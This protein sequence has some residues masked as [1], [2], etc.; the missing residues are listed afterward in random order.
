MTVYIPF[1]HLVEII[2]LDFSPLWL[3]IVLKGNT[4]YLCIKKLIIC[5]GISKHIG[6]FLSPPFIDFDA[7]LSINRDFLSRLCCKLFLLL[8]IPSCLVDKSI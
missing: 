3:I 4:I 7:L 5:Y 8:D 6:F 2:F 1:R